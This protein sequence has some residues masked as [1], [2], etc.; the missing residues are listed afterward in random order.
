MMTG[1]SGC[2]LRLAVS[3][4]ILN[5]VKP[6]TG[7]QDPTFFVCS[8]SPVV[9]LRRSRPAVSWPSSLRSTGCSRTGPRRCARAFV[10][11]AGRRRRGRVR[12][13]AARG[14]PHVRETG[15]GDGQTAAPGGSGRA[16]ANLKTIASDADAS[17]GLPW[18]LAFDGSGREALYLFK[19]DVFV[20]DLAAAHFRRLTSTAAEEKSGVSRRM[21]AVSPTCETTTST[22]ST[23]QRTAIPD[24]ARRLGN[25]AERN[26]LVGLLGGGLRPT[27]YRILVVARFRGDRLPPV[28]R[29]P[30]GP[31]LFRGLHT[32]LAARHPAAL[33]E[34]RPGKPARPGRDR[35]AWARGH[36]VG[37]S[38]R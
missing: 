15:S 5:E 10:H 9:W 28:G 7:I 12:H 27:R 36:D 29:L 20:L 37:S 1:N 17:D 14:G 11:M 2:H 25:H 38:R 35:R 3:S 23:W 16:L 13:A 8:C 24:H 31:L 34:S 18:P 22:F 6:C 30:G 33:C 4:N 19:G 26:A 21:A 32:L